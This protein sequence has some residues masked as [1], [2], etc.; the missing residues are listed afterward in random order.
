MDGAPT[1][2]HASATQ[3]STQDT[4]SQRPCS[5]RVAGED[6]YYRTIQREREL[7]SVTLFSSTFSPCGSYLLAASS[8]GRVAV[9]NVKDA[10]ANFDGRSPPVFSFEA[11]QD[12]IYKMKFITDEFL[13]TA[14]Q[15]SILGWKW[16]DLMQH[17]STGQLTSQVSPVLRIRHE[18]EMN[19]N[20]ST[21]ATYETN[22]FAYSKKTNRLYCAT[23]SKH[24]LC[25]DLSGEPKLLAKMSGHHKYLHTVAVSD[26]HGCV[27]SGSEDGTVRVFDTRTYQCTRV[28]RPSTGKFLS[29]QEASTPRFMSKSQTISVLEFDDDEANLIIGGAHRFV[30][31]YHFPSMELATTMPTRSS[32]QCA[33]FHERKLLSGGNSSQF[34]VWKKS[35][36]ELVHSTD[37][38][39]KSIWSISTNERTPFHSVFAVCGSGKYVDLFV[40]TESRAAVL[41]YR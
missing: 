3:H 17:L 31:R 5:P 40:R 38:L 12:C 8:E 16:Q 19:S 13:L 1:A 10:L 29:D 24:L 41:E 27:L 37:V 15:S 32:P 39:S 30:S 7:T 36:G 9:W 28:L 4:I 23:G 20:G 33:T 14:G 22:D 35:N 21:D 26:N 18:R 2:P 25:Y 6:D 11:H 34:F